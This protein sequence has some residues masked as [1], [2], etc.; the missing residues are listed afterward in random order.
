VPD[1][2]WAAVRA[3]IE[4]VKAETLALLVSSGDVGA[5][6]PGVVAGVV[7]AGVKV[8]VGVTRAGG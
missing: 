5:E 1:E 4:T 2:L 7:G 8:R 3:R 6:R